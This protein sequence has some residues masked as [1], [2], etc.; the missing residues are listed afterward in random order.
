MRLTTIIPCFNRRD[1]IAQAVRT[2]LD[3]QLPEGCSHK[4]VVIDDCST[5]DSVDVLTSIWGSDE[6]NDVNLIRLPENRGPSGARN[7]GIKQFWKDTDVFATLDSDDGWSQGRVMRCL[8]EFADPVIGAVVTDFLIIDDANGKMHFEYREPFDLERLKANSIIPSSCFVRKSILEL[9]GLYD[10]SMRVSE[11][12]DLFL[13]IGK[14]AVIKHIPEP[15]MTYVFHR[16]NSSFKVPMETWQKS[17]RTIAE[18]A[19]A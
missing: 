11:D 3:Q 7:A 2:A 10:E 6:Y 15:L 9:V 16:E 12:W 8:P 13:R 17:W 1:S 19:N 4:V 5:D 18:R 14:K